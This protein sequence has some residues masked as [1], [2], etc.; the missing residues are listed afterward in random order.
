MPQENMKTWDSYTN[1]DRILNVERSFVKFVYF[2]HFFCF[3][4]T[5][6]NTQ[7]YISVINW[8]HIRCVVLFRH[9]IQHTFVIH[10]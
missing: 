9:S 8:K 1:S 10:V 2:L 6:T 5:H 4:I 7:G 3:F